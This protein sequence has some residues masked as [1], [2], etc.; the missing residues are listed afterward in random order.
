[1]ATKRYRV[2]HGTLSSGGKIY[3]Q[4]DTIDTDKDLLQHNLAGVD[5]FLL[6]GDTPDPSN[7]KSENSSQESDAVYTREELEQMTVPDLREIAEG[8]EIDL[9]GASKKNEII[10]RL[11]GED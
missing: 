8:E 6:I 2:M 3:N 9:M 4:G 1:M 11:L 5:K 7:S 10:S